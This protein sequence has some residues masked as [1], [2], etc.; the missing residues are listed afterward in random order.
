M[1]SA[2][3]CIFKLRKKALPKWK[4]RK[5]IFQQPSVEADEIADKQEEPAYLLPPQKFASFAIIVNNMT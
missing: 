3:L 2:I 1:S 5:H 4:K